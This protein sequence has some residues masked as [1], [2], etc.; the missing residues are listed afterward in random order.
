MSDKSSR[1]EVAYSGLLDISYR[2]G[3]NIIKLKKHNRGLPALF[4]YLARAVVGDSE[5]L[6]DKPTFLDVRYADDVSVPD[7]SELWKSCLNAK[8]PFSAPTYEYDVNLSTWKAVFNAVIAVTSLM[9]LQTLGNKFFRLYMCSNTTNFACLDI[10]YGDL[11]KITPGTQGLV[12]WSI[13]LNNR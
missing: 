1:T 2:V 5:V 13:I 12:E 3:D 10:E 4:K 7:D 6:S 8:I 9:D 11:T